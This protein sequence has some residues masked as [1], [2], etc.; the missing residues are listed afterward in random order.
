LNIPDLLASGL[1]ALVDY[2]GY[3]VLTCLVPAFLLAGAIVAFLPR[4]VI[5]RYLGSETRKRISLPLASASGMFVAACSCTVIPIASGLYR[6]G[7]SIGPAFVILWVTPAANILALTYTGAVLGFDMAA[8]RLAAAML[9]GVIV[10]LVMSTVFRKDENAR[11]ARARP[12]P[13]S[14]NTRIFIERRILVLLALL[15]LS[16]LIPNYLGGLSLHKL[17]PEQAYL[18]NPYVFKVELFLAI[19][20]VAVYYAFRRLSS[21]EVNIWLRETWWFVRQ[22]LPLLLAG[23]F[24]VGVIGKLIPREFVETYLGGSSLTSSFLATLIGAVSYFATMTEAPFVKTL[25]TLGMGKGPALG[26]LLAGPGE[27]LPN[28]LAISRVFGLRK[29]AV[30]VA[31]TIAISTITAYIAGNTIWR[32]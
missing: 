17:L 27:S 19:L 14:S 7:G 13:H 20:A 3:H 25:I 26:L 32:Q 10:G 24:V 30:Y 1:E 2:V 12:A 22:I 23:V 8:A 18:G 29:A 21:D 15:A 31:T 16:L 11:W 5:I 9:T 6:K 28:W 4:D